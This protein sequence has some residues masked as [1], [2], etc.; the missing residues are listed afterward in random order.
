MKIIK[1]DIHD[2]IKKI[3]TDS[4]NLIYSDVPF[5]ITSNKKWDTIKI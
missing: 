4:I 1:G 5:G 3:E 2:E